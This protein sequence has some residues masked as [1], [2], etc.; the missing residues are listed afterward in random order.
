MPSLVIVNTSR[1]TDQAPQGKIPFKLQ[2]DCSIYV[3]DSKTH[4][5][6]NLSRV[7]FIIEMK[8]KGDPFV[9]NILP[10]SRDH[11]SD[12]KEFYPFVRLGGRSQANDWIDPFSNTESRIFGPPKH[13]VQPN[14]G[15]FT[16][17]RTL[18]ASGARF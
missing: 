18:G 8:S 4:G 9:V 14:F 10:N 12:S 17:L 15:F 11:T 16:I 7:D 13:E 5:D 6:L 1:A 2:S 3:T